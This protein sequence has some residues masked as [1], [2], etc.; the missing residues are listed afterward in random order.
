[1]KKIYAIKDNIIIEMYDTQ[2]NFAVDYVVNGWQEVLDAVIKGD[3]GILYIKGTEPDFTA[4]RTENQLKQAQNFIRY[5]DGT[6][7]SLISQLLD[8]QK[9][10]ATANLDDEL[11]EQWEKDQFNEKRT[12]MRAKVTELA[13]A[14]NIQYQANYKCPFCGIPHNKELLNG[15]NWLECARCG[16]ILLMSEA[17]IDADRP[18]IA[19][20]RE[21]EIL[22]ELVLTDSIVTA[23]VLREANL[24]PTEENLPI[25]ENARY[26]IQ[27]AEDRAVELRVELRSLNV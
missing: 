17:P 9:L 13:P 27:N 2:E 14:G 24:Q 1:M 7:P 5:G 19:P 11:T 15:V 23:R 6:E 12:E 21:E 22:K 25:I 8:L 10:I 3:D 20:T 4:L 26:V 16:H 18:F